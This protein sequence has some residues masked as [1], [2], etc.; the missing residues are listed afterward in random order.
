MVARAA[1]G[2][3]VFIEALRG[4]CG[5]AGMA[6]SMVN[7]LRRI[8]ASIPEL[9]VVADPFQ[10]ACSGSASRAQTCVRN[11]ERCTR[12]ERSRTR[13]CLDAAASEIAN[14]GRQLAHCRGAA[15]AGASALARRVRSDSAANTASRRS[16]QGP[17]PCGVVRMDDDQP[18][19]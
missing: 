11:T 18:C 16:A 7:R 19:G 14:G 8:Q 5:S 6:C 10:A 15:P 4:G 9:L 2:V 13:M 12:P 17:A 3:A 1:A